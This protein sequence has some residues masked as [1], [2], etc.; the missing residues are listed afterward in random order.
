VSE[1]SVA[2]PGLGDTLEN[3]PEIIADYHAASESLG[4]VGDALTAAAQHQYDIAHKYTE[5]GDHIQEVLRGLVEGTITGEVAKATL[6][7]YV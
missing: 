5:A 2:V 6:A 3:M 4:A 7:I 1:A